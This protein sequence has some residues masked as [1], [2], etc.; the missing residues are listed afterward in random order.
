MG[1]DLV[2]DDRLAATAYGIATD[3]G[4]AKTYD[5]EYIGLARLLGCRLVTLDARLARGAGRIAEI[6]APTEL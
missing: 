1:V 4:W 5:A 2:T 6:V 3:L